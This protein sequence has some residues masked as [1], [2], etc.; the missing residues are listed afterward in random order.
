M[1]VV[2]A[3]VVDVLVTVSVVGGAVTVVVGACTE[4]LVVP[5]LE[6]ATPVVDVVVTVVVV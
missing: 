1:V 5:G 4:M 6:L 3:V 2:V